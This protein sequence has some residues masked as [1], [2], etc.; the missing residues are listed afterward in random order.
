MAKGV[1]IVEMRAEHIPG[2]MKLVDSID[3]RDDSYALHEYKDAHGKH[4][5]HRLSSKFNKDFVMLLN[6]KVAGVTGFRQEIYGHKEIY[7]MSWTVV[8]NRYRGK[9]Y[10]SLLVER[11]AKE[12]KKLGCRKLYV[13]TTNEK[14]YASAKEFYMKLGFKP[15][16]VLKDYYRKGGNCIILA[17]TMRKQ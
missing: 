6:K 5:N 12:V 8:G 17:R 3:P 16:A 15:E 4:K 10:G 13:N 1:S 9:G 14:P 7:W 11:V 2:V